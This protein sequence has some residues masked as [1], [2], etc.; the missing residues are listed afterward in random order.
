MDPLPDCSRC[1]ELQAQVESLKR[2]VAQLEVNLR[3]SKRQAVPFGGRTPQATPKKPGRKK[4]RGRFR[5]REPPTESPIE[6]VEVRLGCCPR[7]RGELEDRQTHEHI[8]TDL[9]LPRPVHKRFLTE[10]GYCPRCRKRVRSRHPEQGSTAAGAA[11]VSVGPNAKA[12]A[13]DL[14]HR[15][16]KAKCEVYQ[17]LRCLPCLLADTGQHHDR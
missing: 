11:G 14:H 10:S 16:G 9:P 17:Q 4:G 2:R 6:T 13:A 15:P 1:R 8:Q 12:V 5:R 3:A 7:C